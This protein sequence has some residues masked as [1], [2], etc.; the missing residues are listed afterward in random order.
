[1]ESKSKY[2]FSIEYADGS[3]IDMHEMG[4]WV[5]YFHILSPD[6]E[7]KLSQIQGRHG[8]SQTSSRIGKRKIKIRFQME[9]NSAE[10][11]ESL[12]HQVFHVFYQ[13]QQFKIVRD[14]FPTKH[15]FAVQ[16]G[17]YDL[18]NITQE[19]AEFE[20]TLTMLDP[21]IY[22]QE[23]GVTLND[24]SAPFI[25][26]N[27]G[28]RPVKP[29]FKFTLSGL[30]THLDIIGDTDYMR[31]GQPYTVD[32]TPYLSHEIIWTADGKDLN[33]WVFTSF[34]PD[35]AVKSGEIAASGEDFFPSTYGTGSNWHGPALVQSVG[36]V[37]SNYIVTAY[38][39]LKA[40]AGQK[41]RAEVYMLNESGTIIGKIAVVSRSTTGK[42][43]VEINIR[44]GIKQHFLVSKEWKFDNFFG[45]IEIKKDD[46]TFTG[47]V[48]QQEFNVEGKIYTRYKEQFTFEDLNND[49]QLD[50]AAI[51]QHFAAYGTEQVPSKSTI[52]KIE[53]EKLNEQSNGVPYIGDN[54][55]VFE[56]DFKSTSILRN[57]EPFNQKDFGARFFDLKPGDN[58]FVASPS[59]VIEE[60]QVKWRD[61]EL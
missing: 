25:L 26:T 2:N 51:S 41:G 7:R 35:G 31:I 39:S 5:E 59:N 30:T 40:N 53:A 13:D 18:D 6:V 24:V 44:N 52:R 43:E 23:R 20:L 48:A 55:D 28:R 47:S 54:G 9:A 22:G 42:V 10:E 21:F 37:R 38:F 32:Q 19:D 57:G 33:D 1:M 58:I 14:I 34:S 29:N 4:L 49:Y 27:Y 46:K 8:A 11:F 50:L 45:Y 61:I 3:I 56:I 36:S 16:E 60:L 15:L 17:E 12:K